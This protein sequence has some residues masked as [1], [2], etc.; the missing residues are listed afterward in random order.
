MILV[1]TVALV[2]CNN[3]GDDKGKDSDN[4]IVNQVYFCGKVIEVY[5]K[6]CLVEVI[7]IGNQHLIIGD[8]VV[9]HTDIEGC[10]QYAVGDCLKIV[11]D[12][13]VTKSNPPQIVNVYG[14][15]KTDKDG[16]DIG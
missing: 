9:V 4:D 14:I 13:K 5:D 15:Y 8:K 7:R 2:A 16:N 12:G 11:F 6:S 10:P 1:C 3:N